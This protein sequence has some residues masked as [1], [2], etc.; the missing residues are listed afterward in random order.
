MK[1][2][3][4]PDKAPAEHQRRRFRSY[5]IDITAYRLAGTE[6]PVALTAAKGKGTFRKQRSPA[7]FVAAIYGRS[8]Y[9]PRPTFKR[10]RS[11]SAF[12]KLVVIQFGR[13][14]FRF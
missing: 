9:G 12:G 11:M 14:R 4:G 3:S 13:R 8:A 2:K 1:Q 6:Y 7:R 10:H 5:S